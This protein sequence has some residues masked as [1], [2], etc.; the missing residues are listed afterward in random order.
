V[1]ER[2]GFT[3]ELLKLL[4]KLPRDLPEAQFAYR[5]VIYLMGLRILEKFKDAAIGAGPHDVGEQP[6][7]PERSVGT[8]IIVDTATGTGGQSGGGHINA[9][10]PILNAALHLK[11]PKPVPPKSD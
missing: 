3:D 5:K 11:A 2:D 4:D 7:Y 9:I 6:I 1:S 10:I 8:I